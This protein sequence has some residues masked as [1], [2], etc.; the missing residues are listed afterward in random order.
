M[1]TRI[2]MTNWS[3]GP[4]LQLVLEKVFFIRELA[5]KPEHLLFFFGERLLARWV[6]CI[7]SQRSRARHAR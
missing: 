3:G 6:S 2:D 7:R 1:V 5:V 4:Y